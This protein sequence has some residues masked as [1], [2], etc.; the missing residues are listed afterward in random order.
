MRLDEYDCAFECESSGPASRPVATSAVL[1][2][3]SGISTRCDGDLRD[4][5]TKR[6]LM[7]LLRQKIRQERKA[8]KP[9]RLVR[10]T[11]E[12]SYRIPNSG[13]GMV[14]VV[15]DQTPS[16]CG[17]YTNVHVTDSAGNIWTL[18]KGHYE[19]FEQPPP[20][21]SDLALASMKRDFPFSTQVGF[22]E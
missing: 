22:M 13:P 1:H 4:P 19:V 6:V 3:P 18:G 16:H 11:R 14:Y 17:T 9:D 15:G 8:G 2:K 10:L 7:D 21:V 20:A 5:N 12:G